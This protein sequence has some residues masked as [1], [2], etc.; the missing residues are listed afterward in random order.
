MEYSV[1]MCKIMEVE[2]DIRWDMQCKCVCVLGHVFFT[3][4]PN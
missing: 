1:S 2:C 4:S 3:S